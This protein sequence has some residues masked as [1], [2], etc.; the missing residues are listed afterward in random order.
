MYT[1][2]NLSFFLTY[3]NRMRGSETKDVAMIKM[4]LRISAKINDRIRVRILILKVFCFPNLT[5]EV[6]APSS[7]SPSISRIVEIEKID[8]VAKK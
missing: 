8:A 7:L 1:V 5:A 2:R 3:T 6:I 4:S